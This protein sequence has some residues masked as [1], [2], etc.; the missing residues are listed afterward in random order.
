[1]SDENENLNLQNVHDADESHEYSHSNLDENESM[2]DKLLEI[3]DS[4][5]NK[6]KTFEGIPK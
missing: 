4:G 1:M 6:N 5:R 2:L 3:G